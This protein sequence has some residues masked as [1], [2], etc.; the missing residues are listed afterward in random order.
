MKLLRPDLINWSLAI[1]VLVALWALGTAYA[2]AARLRSPTARRFAPLSRRSTPARAAAVVVCGVVAAAGLEFALLRPQALLAARTPDYERQDVV[3]VLDRSASMRAH[4]VAPSRFRRATAEIRAF[5]RE[6]PDTIDRVGLVGFADASVVLSY[7]T[8]DVDSILFYLD[9]IDDDPTALLGTNIGAA[10]RSAR[11]VARKD[12]RRTGKIFLLVSDGEDYGAEL[13]DALAAF[14]EEGRRVHC[15]GIGSDDEVPVPLRQADGQEVPLRDD[16]G[17]AVM[18][19][20]AES[21]LRHIAS[22]TGGRYVRSRDGGEL[23]RAIAD[24]VKGERRIVGWRSTTEY[25]DVYRAGLVVA[26]VAGAALW[27]LL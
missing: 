20:F 16:A 1:P 12:D 8:G 21:T 26:G 17:R 3:F 22:T 13:D 14:R 18:T 10:L 7:L 19:K 27:M 6:K 5:L 23:A 24:I 9:W 2:R 4:D 11:D 25:R 15:I